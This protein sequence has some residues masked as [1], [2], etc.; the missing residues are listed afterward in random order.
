MPSGVF[1]MT[2]IPDDQIDAVAAE[3][4]LDE[5][6][7]I[8]REK[9]PDGTWTLTVSF[10]PDNQ[11]DVVQ[12]QQF[13]AST[14][15]TVGQASGEPAAFIQAHLATARS[16]R[17]QFAIPIAVCLAQS[18]LETGWGRH[19]VGN[20]YF[21]IKA[22]G[23]QPS[24]VTKTHEQRPDGTVFS[25]ND[26]FRSYTGF[27]DAAQDY[28]RFL[29]TNPRYKPAFQHSEDPEAFARAIAAAGFATALNYGDLLVSIIRS[30]KL[31]E[32]A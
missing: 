19:V 22:T 24:V 2:G 3:A 8:S 9:Q 5:P 16:I 7:R 30:H 25:E 27:D 21:G 28:G 17:Q 18:A 23:N 11:P 29:T 10:P 26:A 4:E 31:A 32:L 13:G 12:T 15:Q 1:I 20:A 6:T 14:R